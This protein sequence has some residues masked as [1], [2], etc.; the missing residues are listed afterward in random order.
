[1]REI[2]F[3]IIWEDLQEKRHK[4]IVTLDNLLLGAWELPSNRLTTIA[5]RQYTGLQDKNEKDIYEGDILTDG[6]RK[7]EVKWRNAPV[8]FGLFMFE[9]PKKKFDG[10]LGRFTTSLMDYQCDK[11]EV[12]GNIY[13]NPE[14]LR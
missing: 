5:R 7:W 13:E 3:E 6:S 2:K 9:K 12:I 1:M 10:R 14:L 11:L 4:Q 8:G